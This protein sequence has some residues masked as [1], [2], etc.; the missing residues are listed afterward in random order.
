MSQENA[1]TSKLNRP[2][3]GKSIFRVPEVKARPAL[4]SIHNTVT[5]RNPH[6][7]S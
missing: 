3:G 5:E 2:G 1:I 7:V 6:E 4:G